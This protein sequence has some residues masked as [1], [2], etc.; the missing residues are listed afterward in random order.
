MI[1][2]GAVTTLGLQLEYITNGTTLLL[3]WLAGGIVALCGAVTYA[4]LGSRMPKSGGEAH[5]LGEIFHPVLGFLSGWVSVTVGFA[6]AVALS[7]VA[8]GHYLEAILGWPPVGTAAAAIILLSA[9]HSLGNRGSSRIQN[10]LTALKLLVVLGLGLACALLPADPVSPTLWL[11]P[12]LGELRNGGAAVALI[13]VLYA[14]SG[15]NAAAYIVGEIRDPDRN[16]PRALI[17]GTALVTILFLL[18]QFGFLRQAGGEALRGEIEVGRVAAEVMLGPAFGGY[19]SAVIGLLLLTGISAMIWVGPRV[20]L[21]MGD[22]HSLWRSFGRLS[23]YGVPL[24][25]TWLQAAISLFLVFTASFERVLLYSE[26][27]LQLFT[28]MAV[29]GLIVLR[30]R[31]SAHAGYRAPFFPVPQILFLGFTG[32]SLAYLL[33][34]NPVESLLGLLNLVTGLIAYRLR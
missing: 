9:L 29:L 6:A 1:G 18:L 23:Q 12:S 31:R 5:F 28:L 22:Q 33:V 14:F 13:G 3:I 4:E 10:S 32:W 15:W 19:V 16:L 8:V 2:T 34:H 27:V 24:R 17:G 30:Y 26:F 11:V 20:T 7:A 21:A 25:A